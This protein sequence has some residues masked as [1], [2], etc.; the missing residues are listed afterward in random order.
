MCYAC[1]DQQAVDKNVD[2]PTAKSISVR[3]CYFVTNVI[4]MC[5]CVRA[6]ARAYTPPR[7]PMPN[8]VFKTVVSYVICI[9]TVT[10]GMRK[11]ADALT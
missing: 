5:V 10:A 9:Y 1:P 7:L 6:L 8:K 2:C 3:D 4:R 11:I